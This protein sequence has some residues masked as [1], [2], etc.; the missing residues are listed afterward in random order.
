MTML[1]RLLPFFR[2]YWL[3][4]LEAGL[5]MVFTTL[6]ALPMPLL[7]I[8]IIDHVVANGQTSVLHIV[9]GTLAL[10]VALG[11]GMGFLQHCLLLVFTRR[12]F[13]DLE[14]KLFRTVHT[15]PI[16]FFRQHASAYIATRVSDDVR[17][18]RSLMAGTYI[19]GLSSLALLIAAMGIMLAIHPSLA[20]IVVV[21]LPGFA[22]INLHFGRQVQTQSESVQERKALAS[23]TRLES[24]DS[25]R[26]VRAF[27]RG[28]QEEIRLA[29]AIH[30]EVDA[31]LRRD[32]TTAIAQTLQMF[33][34]SVGS[35][36]LLW[37]GAHEMIEERL[38]LGQ[39]VAFTTLLAYVY[40]PI[41]QL[42]GLYVNVR[43][44]LGVL[45]RVLDIL[46]TPPELGRTQ[47]SSAL[48]SSGGVTFENIAFGY[49]SRQPILAGV[50]FQ[51]EPGQITA[52][53]GRT[54]AGK[55]TIVNLL[56][57]FFEPHSGRILIDGQDI[58]T[59]EVQALRAEIGYVE[60]D[61][62][63]FSGSIGENIAYGKSGATDEEIQRA[64]KMM[65]CTDFI[66]RFPEGLDTRIGS[67]GVQLSG[68]QKQRIA[69]ARAVIRDP[70]ILILDE[71]TSSLDAHSEGIVQEALRRACRGRTTL[72]IAHHSP[73]VSIA[74]RILV[75]SGGT[76]TQEGTLQDLQR[77]N[78]YFSKSCDRGRPALAV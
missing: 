59:L 36:S 67:G 55:I 11:L 52:I 42:S 48:L 56:L 6:L 65:N 30:R 2:P 60:Q 78:G 75:L 31:R 32:T 1:L 66:Q 22:W 46:D 17:Q 70:M 40:G 71:A 62:R 21:F 47:G 29:R 24:L 23:A 54:G 35:L 14:M 37:Y 16:A 33:L 28:T 25:A 76:I 41:H 39:F 50:R 43:Q 74:D 45:E 68:G 77:P 57:R 27:E 15:L 7:S 5:C 49:D 58:R 19:Q 9:C 73:T 8:Y 44:G 63:L 69:L 64:A 3:R 53:V 72:L 20:I 26:S 4:G 18:L 51:L 34:Y 10:A 12:I 61:V 38:T 13:F